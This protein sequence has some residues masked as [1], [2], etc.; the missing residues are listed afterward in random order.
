MQEGDWCWKM[1]KAKKKEGFKEGKGRRKIGKE[2]E[3]SGGRKA[4]LNINVFY[5]EG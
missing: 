2:D 4:Y 3:L 5:T 1:R